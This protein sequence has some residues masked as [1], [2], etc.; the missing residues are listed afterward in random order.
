[1]SIS[2]TVRNLHAGYGQ[3]TVIEGIDIDA[4]AGEVVA[5]VGANG[6]GKTTLLNTIAGVN[7]AREGTIMLGDLDITRMAAHELPAR[8]LALVPEGGRLFPFM[9]VRENLE[10]GGFN[11]RGSPRFG[12]MLDEVMEL[13]PILRQRQGQ[14]AGS[15]SGGERQMCAIARAVMSQPQL[16]MLDEPSVGLSPKLVHQVFELVRELARKK[17]LT[18]V[19]VEQNVQEALGVSDR[20][21]VLDHGAIVRSAPSAELSGDPAIQSAYMGL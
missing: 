12:Q 10:M 19:L 7:P 20:A 16:I 15:L 13:F 4:A 5:I 11:Q 18:I 17:G 14:W 6:A 8:G 1:M 3:A 2:L 9:T 21:Y